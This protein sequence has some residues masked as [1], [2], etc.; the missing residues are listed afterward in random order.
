[1]RHVYALLLSVWLYAL[2]FGLSRPS[3]VSRIVRQSL[4]GASR[5][6]IMLLKAMRCIGSA[7]IRSLLAGGHRL[8]GSSWSRGSTRTRAQRP[9]H[10]RCCRR[11]AAAMTPENGAM[12]P[13]AALLVFTRDPRGNATGRKLVL[14]TILSSVT[15]LGWRAT[16]AHFGRAEGPAFENG[17]RFLALSAPTVYELAT[18]AA[19]WLLHRRTSLNE[20]LYASSQAQ[21]RLAALLAEGDTDLVITD[22]VRTARYGA[23]S[24]LPWIADLDDLL[25]RR[26][27]TAARA[28]GGGGNLLGYHRAPVLGA[29]L[30]LELMRWM[31]PPSGI[32]MP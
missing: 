15:D 25:S 21:R 3:A 22:M 23:A 8:A 19:G 2:R 11:G 30:S 13:G 17:V 5:D 20:V 29:A 18:G 4:V 14:R 7:I 31:P 32:S 27:A 1:M 10:G 12:R 26:Y 16:V 28:R 24:G 6:P 9:C